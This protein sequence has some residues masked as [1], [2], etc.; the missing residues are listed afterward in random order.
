MKKILLLLLTFILLI[1]TLT[2][3]SSAEGDFKMKEFDKAYIT[4]VFDDGNMPFTKEC[5]Y[6]FKAFNAPM[7]CA[8][9][10]NKVDNNPE[11]ISILKEV[12]KSGGEVLSHTYTHSAFSKNSTVSDFEFQLRNSYIH[13]AGLGFK[14]NGVIEAGNGGGEAEANYEL[15]ETVTRKYYKYSN[16][17]GVSPQYKKKRTWFMYNNL[18]SV[19]VIIDEAIKNK[20][21]VVFAAHSFNEFS[22]DDMTETLRYIKSKSQDE[23]AVVNWNYIYENFGEYTGPQVPTADA[24][25]AVKNYKQKLEENSNPNQSGH[26]SSYSSSN[27]SSTPSYSGNNKNDSSSSKLSNN[28][29]ESPVSSSSNVNIASNGASANANNIANSGTSD[30]TTNQTASDNTTNN[31]NN[32]TAANTSPSSDNNTS[33]QATSSS[34]SVENQEDDLGGKILLGAIIIA[35]VAIACFLTIFFVLKSNK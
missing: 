9:V 31:N 35:I 2:F 14:I 22:Q 34:Q 30:S 4:F 16:A 23:I 32:T 26:N 27:D 8:V 11:L 3:T 17:Y 5:Y 19:K 13:L 15:M 18:N 20:E 10:A 29:A 12:E 33:S 1:S 28:S 6:L 21:W 25:K 24:L 7:C